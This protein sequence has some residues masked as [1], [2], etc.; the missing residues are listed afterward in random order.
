MSTNNNTTNNPTTKPSSSSNSEFIKLIGFSPLDLE[1]NLVL[2]EAEADEYDINKELESTY[3]TM[4]DLE[5][6]LSDT[7]RTKP[8]KEG[9]PSIYEL[10]RISSN[11]LT[12][13]SILFVNKANKLKTFTEII[14]FQEPIFE[15][16]EFFFKDVFK[17]ITEQNFL[18]FLETNAFSLGCAGNNSKTDNSSDNDKYKYKL[19]LSKLKFN[20]KIIESKDKVIS[21]VGFEFFQNIGKESKEDK[22]KDMDNNVENKNTNKETNNNKDKT[23]FLYNRISY[24]FSGTNYF[25]C[26]LSDIM[27]V[28]Y[29]LEAIAK[30]KEEKENQDNNNQ[31]Q[32]TST[33]ELIHSLELFLYLLKQLTTEYPKM[34]II[35]VCPCFDIENINYESLIY[36]KE[37]INYADVFV[38][39]SIDAQDYL[40]TTIQN[41]HQIKI[42]QEI[43]KNFEILFLKQI[44]N[45]K[46]N[47][48]PKL[49]IFLDGMK[50]VSI[51]EQ[52]QET[53]LVLA[54]TD[55]F[56]D[57]MPKT[58][59]SE[60]IIE[61]EELII[62]HKDFL[63]SVFLG[64][65][66]S[67]LLHKK[68]FINC[69]KAGSESVKRILELIRFNM[70][71]PLDQNYYTIR[72]KKKNKNNNNGN[73]GNCK[74]KPNSNST[75]NTQ[76]ANKESNFNLDCININN[77]KMK[78][79][80]PLYDNTLT[81]FFSSINVRQHLN[82]L[83]FIN[84]KGEVLQDPDKKRMSNLKNKK[85]VRVYEKEQLKLQSIKENNEKMKLQITN[86]IS[87]TKKNIQEMP[88]KELEKL[89]KVMNFNPLSKQKLPSIPHYVDV[90]KLGK[91]TK[92]KDL[93]AKSVS[94][95]FGN[96]NNSN[97][98]G[99]TKK[100]FSN[101]KYVPSNRKGLEPI[102][103]GGN[104]GGAT[105]Y[106]E[107]TD[108]K[109]NNKNTIMENEKE[110]IHT[111]HNVANNKE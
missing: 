48:F 5:A 38:I 89:T 101:T 109:N 25:L 100:S 28:S 57:L 46:K 68:A 107:N 63:K 77:C 83:G 33:L 50:R 16:D 30:E 78:E 51:I 61:Y 9:I 87:G 40:S 20:I 75:P 106:K 66:F 14:I 60:Q 82:K 62:D 97:S 86:L 36:F 55:F 27:T 45:V 1:I 91:Y 98:N 19:N 85:L 73:G 31:E 18:F 35:L 74:N 8:D 67:R 94:S 26:D 4:Q 21:E 47:M 104:E 59:K 37:I 15:K 84:K 56:F 96:K 80:N 71:F 3:T 65:F 53:S 42:S 88:I 52:L 81:T 10:M 32:Q 108:H 64:G 72:I 103:S 12:L 13:N 79:Y 76:V 44:K 34:R 41:S 99:N 70:E 49:G 58:L 92:G 17:H 90:N 7:K 6:I 11:N 23:S 43:K 69:F 2:T 110:D 22:C 39:N 111:E 54:H 24:D 29:K 95:S 102:S 105:V 93:Y